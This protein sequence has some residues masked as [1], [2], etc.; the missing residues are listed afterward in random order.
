MILDFPQNSRK[1][2]MKSEEKIPNYSI[3]LVRGEDLNLHPT[4]IMRSDATKP[5]PR[6]PPE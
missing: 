2:V 6:H 5:P 3:H 4:T 1:C